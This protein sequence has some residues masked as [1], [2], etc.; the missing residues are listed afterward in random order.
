MNMFKEICK[1][2]SDS[3]KNSCKCVKN[4]VYGLIPE[5]EHSFQNKLN[6]SPFWVEGDFV[7]KIGLDNQPINSFLPYNHHLTN[8]QIYNIQEN[9]KIIVGENEIKSRYNN[10]LE[11][12]NDVMMYSEEEFNL[13]QIE[14]NE[15]CVNGARE[16]DPLTIQINNDNNSNNKD[17]NNTPLRRKRNMYNDM[18]EPSTKQIKIDS[19]EE[20]SDNESILIGQSAEDFTHEIDEDDVINEAESETEVHHDQKVAV[21]IKTMQEAGNL[22]HYIL[23]WRFI[24]NSIDAANYRI[25]KDSIC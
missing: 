17:Y 14:Y 6:K 22:M 2:F 7:N 10:E 1:T 23:A 13:K 9:W 11:L 3:V 20:L 8:S 25:N 4:I 5:N 16:F 19:L 18:D 15:R 21:K 12:E 24:D